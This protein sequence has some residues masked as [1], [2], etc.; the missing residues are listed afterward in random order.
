MIR[1][2][3]ETLHFDGYDLFDSQDGDIGD[4]SLGPSEREEW[5][6]KVALTVPNRH[7]KKKAQA[8]Y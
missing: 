2:S 8:S 6:E 5:T 7:K 1:T 4:F 3:K